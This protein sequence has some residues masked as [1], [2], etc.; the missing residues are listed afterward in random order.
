MRW[1]FWLMLLANAAFFSWHF[2]RSGLDHESVADGRKTIQSPLLLVSERVEK[3]SLEVS[4][5]AQEVSNSAQS[6]SAAPIVSTKN[7]LWPDGCLRV[8]P[9]ERREH[10]TQAMAQ[11][12]INTGDHTYE[13]AQERVPRDYWVF[14]P[15]QK[16]QAALQSIL[17]RMR[18]VNMDGIVMTKGVRPEAI[19]VGTYNIVTA[20]KKAQEK[21]KSA[22]VEA[23]IEQR[24]KKAAQV[25][26]QFKFMT[27]TQKATLG[28]KV[29]QT[30]PNLQVNN[31]SCDAA[32]I[33]R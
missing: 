15:P 29:R 5:S 27:G 33:I 14:V 13:M 24:F 25:W 32:S 22:G 8:G 6:E 19:S 11:L 26:V 10:A 21:L 1:V 7:E 9:F 17:T 3:P 31:F 4:T 23:V 28:Q 30:F 12:A 16:D 2:S 20:A 18:Q